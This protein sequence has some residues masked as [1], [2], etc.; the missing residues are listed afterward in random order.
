MTDVADRFARQRL[1]GGWDQSVLAAATVVVVGVGALGNEVAKNLAL[2]GMGRLV[3]CDPDT[4]DT[5]NL[6]RAALFSPDDVGSRKVDAARRSLS[7]LA[8]DIAVDVRPASLASGVGLGELADADVVVG[9][10]DSLRARMELLGRCALVNAVL[11]DGGTGPWSGEVRVRTDPETG[12][13]ACSL[14]SFQRG[15]TD[16]PRT[17]AEVQ[18]T[19]HQP[20]S[21]AIS[22][23]TAAWMSTTTLRILFGLEVPYRLLRIEADLGITDTVEPTRDPSCPF[24]AALPPPIA[25][26]PVSHQDR[27]ADLLA[28]LPPGSDPLAWIPFPVPGGHRCGSR[29]APASSG[30]LGSV[31]SG[32]GAMIRQ[33]TGIRLAQAD[34]ASRLADLGVAPQEIL[35]VR[36]SQGEIRC[37]RLAA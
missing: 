32:C 25:V 37:L 8:P 18:P 7:R 27:V 2:A 6:S 35:P 22:A 29:Q 24:H 3:L 9:C 14:T 12:C 36:D 31:C 34:A 11:V 10:L 15:V 26:L 28:A 4:V 21:V 16:L 33:R 23:M 17:C 1:I 30:Q 20:A 13:H 5:T 19:E